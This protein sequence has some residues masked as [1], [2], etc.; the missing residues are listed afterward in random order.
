MP[1]SNIER[2]IFYKSPVSPIPETSDYNYFFV[3]CLN[4]SAGIWMIEFA[5]PL[6]YG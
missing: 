6:T 1:R 3:S 2:G 4:K 5:P